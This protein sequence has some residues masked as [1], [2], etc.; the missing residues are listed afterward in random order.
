LDGTSLIATGGVDSLTTNTSQLVK[1]SLAY[2]R[3][4]TGGGSLGSVGN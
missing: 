1:S 4:K 3:K 2:L